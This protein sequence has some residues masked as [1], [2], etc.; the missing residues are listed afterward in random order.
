MQSNN[1]ETRV[2]FAHIV[3]RKLHVNDRLLVTT[4]TLWEWLASMHGNGT[5]CMHGNGTAC[6]WP[7][8]NC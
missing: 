5:A 3:Y 7:R 1:I 2:P 4:L 8:M 6:I